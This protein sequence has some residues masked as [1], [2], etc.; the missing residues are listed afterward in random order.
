M[1]ATPPLR[2]TA[3]QPL[4]STGVAPSPPGSLLSVL[5]APRLTR[6]LTGMGARVTWP[7]RRFA[8]TAQGVEPPTRQRGGRTERRVGPSTKRESWA[9]WSQSESVKTAIGRS[10]LSGRGPPRH[11]AWAAARATAAAPQPP[12]PRR[13]GRALLRPGGTLQSKC[14]AGCL[15]VPGPSNGLVSSRGDVSSPSG[16]SEILIRVIG[17]RTGMGM[18]D[19]YNL[20]RSF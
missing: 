15:L 19:E 14:L 11:G 2:P 4:G 6:S 9:P 12:G 1:L 5:T 10:A 7:P 16:F 18:F 3:S 8:A 13:P 17:G 20:T